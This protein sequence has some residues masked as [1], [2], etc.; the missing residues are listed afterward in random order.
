MIRLVISFLLVAFQAQAFMGTTNNLPFL[1]PTQFRDLCKQWGITNNGD[2]NV[3]LMN[4][5]NY[6]VEPAVA[7]ID[8]GVRDA[9]KLLGN[10]TFTNK[11]ALISTGVVTNH[12]DLTNVLPGVTILY[13]S[14]TQGQTDSGAGA[15]EGTAVAGVLAGSGSKDIDDGRITG[16]IPGAKIL[17]ISAH[18]DSISHS[19]A[20]NYCLTN[21]AKIILIE[22]GYPRSDWDGE[23]RKY[24]D[25]SLASNCVIVQ[26]APDGLGVEVS[27]TNLNYFDYPGSLYPD[28]Q[29]IIAATALSYDGTLTESHGPYLVAAPG[30]RMA[31][32]GRPSYSTYVYANGTSF[33][34]PHVAGAVALIWAY[35]P[36]ESCVQIC[37][38]I[39]NNLDYLED[40]AG[41]L[42]IYRAMCAEC[43]VLRPPFVLTIQGNVLTID[44]SDTVIVQQSLNLIDWQLFTNVVGPIKIPLELDGK[45][46]FFRAFQRLSEP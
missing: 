26:A 3:L 35:H 31:S 1:V 45:A 7:G 37:Q 42:N 16:I 11:I 32:T 8:C 41:K 36:N 40:C 23:M 43:P 9:W 29:N 12:S 27:S 19:N 18:A 34:A 4:G 46:K 24:M 25:R 13:E 33:A 2:S 30:R 5:T 21:G 17:P 6:L 10:H 44:R 15:G 20:W 39:R 28:Y 22:W 38:R 14:V